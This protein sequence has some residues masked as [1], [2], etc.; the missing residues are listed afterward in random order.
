MFAVAISIEDSR[1]NKKAKAFASNADTETA[2]LGDAFMQLSKFGDA[3]IV[4]DWDI[5]PELDTLLAAIR[6]HVLNGQKIKA[7]KALREV[8][9]M[10]LRAAKAFVDQ[11]EHDFDTPF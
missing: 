11:H 4:L 2:A 3:F 7:I 6:P 8:K 5:M 9:F 1:G 10:D